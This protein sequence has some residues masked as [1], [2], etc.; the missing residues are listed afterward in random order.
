MAKSRGVVRA[1]REKLDA[2]LMRE[3]LGG[4]QRWSALSSSYDDDNCGTPR[5]GLPQYR[6]SQNSRDEQKERAHLIEV[7]KK[8]GLE[9][10][11]IRRSASKKVPREIEVTETYAERARNAQKASDA[12]HWAREQNFTRLLRKAAK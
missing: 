12:Y 9:Q 2:Q 3:A 5:G 10:L 1:L 7:V 6:H 4:Y 11:S 8:S